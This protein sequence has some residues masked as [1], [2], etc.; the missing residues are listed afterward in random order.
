MD[1]DKRIIGFAG[2]TSSMQYV[3]KMEESLVKND[4]TI[5]SESDNKTAASKSKPSSTSTKSATQTASKPKS[6]SS[7]GKSYRK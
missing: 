6:T 5:A 4:S 1:I 7:T 3:T 2:P